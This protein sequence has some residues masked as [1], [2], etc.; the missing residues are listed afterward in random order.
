MLY[1]ELNLY[2]K[3]RFEELLNKHTPDSYRVRTHNVLSIM[4]ELCELIEG[5]MKRKI[6]T[7]ETVE[8][9]AE[10]CKSL[11][12][13]D[14]WIDYSF[15]DKQ[16]LLNKIDSFIKEVPQSKDRRESIYEITS[17]LKY[18][19]RKCIEN[20]TKSY[21]NKLFTYIIGEI[22]KKGDM[23]ADNCYPK[24]METF[25]KAMSYLCTELLRLNHSKNH[26]YFLALKLKKGQISID[27]LKSQ[28]LSQTETNYEVVYK[29]QGNT[30]INTCQTE[31]GFLNN[32]ESIKA[33][34]SDKKYQSFLDTGGNHLF[35]LFEVKALDTYAAI[36]KAKAEFALL[37]DTL[38]LGNNVYAG[39]LNSNVLVIFPKSQGGYFADLRNHDYQLD[40]T[41]NSNP[42]M[43]KLLKKHVDAILNSNNVKDDVKERLKSALRHFR[44]A[45][46]S[47]D[48]ELR[49]VNYWIAL[50]FIFS[51]PISNE[52]T[53]ARIKKH[54]VNV[55]CYSYIAR[56]VNYLETRLK[57]EGVLNDIV[58]VNK[59]DA[60]WGAM[61]G[62]I[63]DKRTQWLFCN[64]KS[65]LSSGDKI[66]KYIC[67]HQT[68][69]EWHLSRIYRMRNELIHEAALKQ[70]I[71]GATSNLR[72]Y[73]VLLLNQLI[74]Y[75]Y[76][77]KMTVSINDFFHEYENRMNT[78]LANK[79]RNY[80]LSADFEISLIC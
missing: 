72:Y 27:D 69:L 59:S 74:D 42:N 41:Y 18:A 21:A 73:L 68:N 75:F 29:M 62:S 57:N 11:I 15:F 58:L 14:E 35:R 25:D 34:L 19:C 50:E 28:L 9:C 7:S 43:S 66:K 3:S 76:N 4:E 5:W 23:D 26:L 67:A 33:K 71:E 10:E 52:N 13:E 79:D 8:L 44:M 16:L 47:S 36:K 12:N 22:N 78:I 51:S 60:D 40:G 45:N 30:Y 6:Q 24:E 65:K 61:I 2:F 46:D 64:L 77:A 1:S 39:K 49:F 53:F 70:D 37:L 48:L 55:L 32:T 54:L 56:N 80:V 31:Y 20:N 17:Q 38:Y 63:S